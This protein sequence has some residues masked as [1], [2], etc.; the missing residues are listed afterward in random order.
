MMRTAISPRFAIRILLNTPCHPEL[1][2]GPEIFT[3][4]C[5]FPRRSL[6]GRLLRVLLRI[7][8]ERRDYGGEFV[9]VHGYSETV[10]GYIPIA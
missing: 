10:G 8:V 4:R 1:V 9:V 3:P 5:K 7:N 6:F 2:E